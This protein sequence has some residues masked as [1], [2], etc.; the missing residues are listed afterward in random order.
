MNNQLYA[1]SFVSG[2]AHFY[3]LPCEFYK[4]PLL[5]LS[6]GTLGGVLFVFVVKLNNV[7]MRFINV[8]PSFIKNN[9]L[10]HYN[11]YFSLILII[12]LLYIFHKR[13][14]ECSNMH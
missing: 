4:K 6:R 11:F 3:G 9:I 10:E 5:C 14:I 12:Y 13:F 8:F 1:I 2:F 7:F